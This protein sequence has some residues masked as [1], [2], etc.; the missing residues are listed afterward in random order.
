MIRRPPRSTLFPY[1]TLFRS[2]PQREYHELS[3]RLPD[4]CI[5]T[6]DSGSA[7]NWWARQLRLRDGMKAA[8]SG[9]LATMCPGVPYA[10]AAKFAYPRQTRHCFGWRRR[11]ADA[12]HQRADRHRQVLAPLERSASDSAGPQQPGP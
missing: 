4:R 9:T 1:T 10:L 2:N 7:T 8:L 12:R 11:D 5:L 3:P 6:A